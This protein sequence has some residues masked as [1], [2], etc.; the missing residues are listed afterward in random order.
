MSVKVLFSKTVKN[1]LLT[2][3][4]RVEYFRELQEE[5]NRLLARMKGI[6]EARAAYELCRR[7]A[8]TEWPYGNKMTKAAE[9]AFDRANRE[10]ES[11]EQEIV[12]R[13][14]QLGASDS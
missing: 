6:Q 9:A 10:L 12:L 7:L 11:L 1:K 2:P 14:K 4:E 13:S 8:E 3:E 5:G